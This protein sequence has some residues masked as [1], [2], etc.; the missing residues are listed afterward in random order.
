MKANL[1]TR[2]EDVILGQRAQGFTVNMT[3]LIVII[4]QE[5]QD[6]DG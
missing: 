5:R 3:M 6:A 4:G 1:G 2:G